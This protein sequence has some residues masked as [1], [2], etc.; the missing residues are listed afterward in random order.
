MVIIILLLIVMI[1][2]ILAMTAVK[3]KQPIREDTQHYQVNLIL[4]D[5]RTTDLLVKQNEH[6]R[7]YMSRRRS[8]FLRY[9]S[10][11]TLNRPLGTIVSWR[12]IDSKSWYDETNQFKHRKE[13]SKHTD[14]S[15]ISD[16]IGWT[17]RYVTSTSP[18]QLV[19]G[20]RHPDD[21]HLF[22]RGHL[23]PYWITQDEITQRNLIPITQ[24]SNKGFEGNDS[25]QLSFGAINSEAMLSVETEF[26][27]YVLGK[28][29]RHRLK[30]DEIF[31]MFVE[32][33]YHGDNFV[34]T[35]INYYLQLITEDGHNRSFEFYG[36]MVTGKS[37][38]RISVPV[39]MSDG[40]I[41]EIMAI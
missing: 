16:P 33:I 32:P 39:Q 17:Q 25:S 19:T 1:C 27:K 36:K 28:D 12:S 40:T 26:R 34:P 38:L 11:D 8:K 10:G 4:H 9:H 37:I 31:Q 7:D 14:H 41:V 24:Y 22:E 23:V 21:Q 18:H 5:Y 6:I 2:I 30:D 3:R 15:L 13:R 29:W 20:D 35:R